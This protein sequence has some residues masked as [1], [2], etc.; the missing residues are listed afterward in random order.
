[1]RVVRYWQEGLWQ[2]IYNQQPLSQ[3]LLLKA[4]TYSQ[5]EILT[6]D[7]QTSI[8]TDNPLAVWVAP[9]IFYKPAPTPEYWIPLWLPATLANNQLSLRSEN[10]LPWVPAGQFDA[11]QTG[12]FEGERAAVDDWLRYEC[13]N[14]ENQLIW[15]NWSECVNACIEALDIFSEEPWQET[16]LA[17][18]FE[19]MKEAMIWPEAALLGEPLNEEAFS[20]LLKQFSEINEVEK[21]QS[22]EEIVSQPELINFCGSCENLSQSVYQATS[23]LL[24]LKDE[25]LLTLRTP[26]GSDKVSCLATLIASKIVQ[27]TIHQ[28]TLPKITYLTMDA[29]EITAL[30][31]CFKTDYP[32]ATLAECQQAFTEY[33]QGLAIYQQLQAEQSTEAELTELQS[34]DELL[35]KSLQGYFAQQEQ[36]KPKSALA[37][38]LSKF[39]KNKQ[40]AAELLSLGEK[41]RRCKTKRT[42]IH[43][44]IVQ[45]VESLNTHRQAQ[46]DWQSWT[47][48]SG[49]SMLSIEE[50]QCSYTRKLFS[51]VM[52]YWQRQVKTDWLL[53][54]PHADADMD[55]VFID[56][57]ERYT[58]Q[59][60]AP[61]LSKAK[62]AIFL[63]DNQEHE[64][65]PA[66]SHLAEERALSK[67]QL[68]DEETIEQMHYKGMMLG[69]G[70]ALTVALAN[71]AAPLI[72]LVPDKIY[73]PD[74]GR[75]L[76]EPPALRQQIEQELFSPFD[77]LH[78]VEIEGVTEKR[79]R[80][81]VNEHEAQTVVQWIL[82]GPLR[83]RQQLIQIFTP[84]KAQQHYLNQQLQ[85]AGLSCAVYDLTS[86]PNQVSDYVIFSPVYTAGC[87]RP[88]VFDRG[89]QHFYRMVARAR[90]GFWIIGDK[91]IFDAKMHSPSG[92][93]AKEF[94]K[95]AAVL[96]QQETAC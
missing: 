31:A 58:P 42:N 68:D 85:A 62:Q 20:P 79:N 78:F 75:F 39:H 13:L 44:K 47:Q 95:K 23:K 88:F 29:N 86:L 50:I 71:S 21:S 37:R 11:C 5:R 66:I 63:G 2:T 38:F 65:V 12:P 40:N 77:G 41:I 59:Q 74:I 92:K 83:S 9:L 84:F 7:L 45:V 22:L 10:V 61:F 17:R 96:L 3:A 80:E 93:L 32:A 4:L 76:G 48:Q 26:I 55:Y 25:P 53:I 94:V 90:C 1:M 36:L 43:R 34:Q 82:S 27:Q 19:V 16:L 54:N 46:R 8:V 15:E 60:I 89:D 52:G 49:M 72:S 81:F 6:G 69:T 14:E 64:S 87:R 30:L 67:H 28:Q 24:S 35:E 91:R 18:G 73:H 70:N 51:M 33:Q 57:A 56:H